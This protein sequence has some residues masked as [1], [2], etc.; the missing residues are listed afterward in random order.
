MLHGILSSEIVRV[1]GPFV[2]DH[3]SVDHDH[4]DENAP[5]TA[6]INIIIAV[7]S[8]PWCDR[9]PKADGEEG[10]RRLQGTEA[11]GKMC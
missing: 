8:S 10:C 11:G 7:W 5:G 4:G 6:T 3:S 2:I 1:R 9:L